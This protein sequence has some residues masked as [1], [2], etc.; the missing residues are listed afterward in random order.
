MIDAEAHIPCLNIEVSRERDEVTFV[1]IP[2][3]PES[4]CL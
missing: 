2:L 1:E 3:V 4:E